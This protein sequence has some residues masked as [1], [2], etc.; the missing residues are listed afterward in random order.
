MVNINTWKKIPIKERNKKCVKCPVLLRC[1]KRNNPKINP[2]ISNK[3]VYR[4]YL[5]EK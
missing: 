1:G 2:L 3:C 4:I 5:E